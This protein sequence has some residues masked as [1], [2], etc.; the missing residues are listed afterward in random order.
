MIKVGLWDTSIQEPATVV[1]F[2]V[3]VTYTHLNDAVSTDISQHLVHDRVDNIFII[4]QYS[5]T[6]GCGIEIGRELFC[7]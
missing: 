2:K 6:K 3:N 4:F 5:Q 1:G 7:S